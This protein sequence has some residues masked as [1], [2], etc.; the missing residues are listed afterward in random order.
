MKYKLLK[1]IV[2][3]QETAKA[4]TVYREGRYGYICPLSG[5][6][7]VY[8]KNTINDFDEWF[9]PIEDEWEP[10]RAEEGDEY[11]YVEASGKVCSSTDSR[12][13]YDN[14][15]YDTGNYFKTQE[16]AQAYA[17]FLKAQEIIRRDAKG[18]KPDWDDINQI[19]WCGRWRHS[20]EVLI[21]ES[22]RQEQSSTIY[23]KSKED[24]SESFEKYQDEWKTYLT[25]ERS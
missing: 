6:G 19:K 14:S 16:G 7:K 11:C 9:A 22:I 2:T 4:G 13:F 23:F 5:E 17:D 18:F 1:D 24:I 15:R 3:P 21:A 25:Y 8:S 20:T 12:H 10:W